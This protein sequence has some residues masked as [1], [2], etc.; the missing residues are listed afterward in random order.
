MS[1]SAA[2][3]TEIFSSIQGEGLLIGLRQVFI[4]FYACNLACTYCDTEMSENAPAPAFCTLE[5]TPGRRDFFKAANPLALATVLQLLREWQTDWPATH[6]SISIT[7]GEPLVY[8]ALLKQ[9]LPELSSI[10]PIYLETN[11]TLHKALSTVIKHL[12]HIAMDIKLP[13]TS[14]HDGL[15]EEHRLFLQIAAQKQ[16]VVKA[17][18][19]SDT[20]DS[21]IISC[22]E[23]ILS[24]DKN[25]PLILQ[26]VTLQN[27]KPGISSLRILELQEV[28]NRYLTEVRVIPQTHKFL[29]LL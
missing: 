11:G 17:V 24:V 15:W 21:E 4:R 16:T 25:I 8:A 12:E 18:V 23:T 26:P 5:K 28:A 13:S 29:G 7:G 6:H 14:G 20:P 27:D 1:N 19:S 22:C 9:W 10:L 2:E 3:L